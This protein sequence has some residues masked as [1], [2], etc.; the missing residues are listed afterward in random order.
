MRNS[1]V[2]VLLLHKTNFSFF[3][4]SSKENSYL[5]NSSVSISFKERS[6]SSPCL[7][8]TKWLDLYK[9]NGE[10]KSRAIPLT[11]HCELF[12][13]SKRRHLIVVALLSLV[14][15]ISRQW[16]CRHR[17]P[18]RRLMSVLVLYEFPGNTKDWKNI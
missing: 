4:Y 8:R 15:V 16:F 11:C 3:D 7:W 18:P 12:L 1:C 9:M 2:P 14:S 6:T 5:L 17:L 13:L 10:K